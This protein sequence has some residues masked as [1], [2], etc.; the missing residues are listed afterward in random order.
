MPPGPATLVV[1]CCVSRRC[2][3]SHSPSNVSELPCV[4]ARCGTGYISAVSQ[5]LMPSSFAVL[6]SSNVLDRSKSSPHSIV[7]ADLAEVSTLT[8]ACRIVHSGMYQL[9]L[10]VTQHMTS[11]NVFCGKCMGVGQSR[12]CMNWY[13]DSMQRLRA[14]LDRCSSSPLSTVRQAGVCKRG[15]PDK[16]D[17]IQPDFGRG[18]KF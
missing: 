10:H 15:G 8:G 4:S 12:R 18:F 9:Q 7:P 6:K 5:A 11:T 14:C 3:L 17:T 2:V 1:T 13:P 16:G